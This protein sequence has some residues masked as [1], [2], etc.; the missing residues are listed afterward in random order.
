MENKAP[1]ELP[2][3]NE[4]F[5]LNTYYLLNN[6]E[7]VNMAGNIPLLPPEIFDSAIKYLRTIAGRKPSTIYKNWLDYVEMFMDVINKYIIFNLLFKS[8]AF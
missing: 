1:Q 2:K 8:S 6:T 7:R 5:S 4:H 3:Y